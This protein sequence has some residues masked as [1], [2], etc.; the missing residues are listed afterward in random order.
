MLKSVTL[1]EDVWSRAKQ[2]KL[3]GIDADGVLTDGYLYYTENGEFLKAFHTLDGF[4][5]K[6]LIQAG[7]EVAILSGRDSPMLRRR[8][9]DLGVKHLYLGLHDKG[10]T[11][12]ALQAGLGVTQAESAFIGDDWIDVPA[13]VRSGLAIAVPEA[14]G[15]VKSFTHYITQRAGGK[16]AVAEVA[17]LILEAQEKLEP[18]WQLA[19]KGGGVGQ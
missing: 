1:S 10:A 19:V 12:D 2:I 17:E 13:L 7:I 4:R 15:R 3:L 11:W 5:I 16:G 8:L 18:L 14:P 6:L 9:G